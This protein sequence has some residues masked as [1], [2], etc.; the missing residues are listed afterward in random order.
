MKR[1]FGVLLML[2]V[3]SVQAADA[4]GLSE[5]S[6]LKWQNLTL[7]S[8]LVEVQ[9]QALSQQ[10]AQIQTE[11]QQLIEAFR[12]E[13]NA[14]PEETFDAETMTFKPKPKP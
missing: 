12:K 13:L 4:P 11:A 5:V 1:I 2:S 7:R 8:N 9:L 3:V 6:K 14:G 10:R